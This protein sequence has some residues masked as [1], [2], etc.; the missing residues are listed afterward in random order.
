MTD[1]TLPTVDHSHD[2]P[3]HT[4]ILA[5]AVFMVFSIFLLEKQINEMI[6]AA[7]VTESN[8]ARK[9][10][11]LTDE[12]KE[13]REAMESMKARKAMTEPSANQ[14]DSAATD[15]SVGESAVA[16]QAPHQPKNKVHR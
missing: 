2:V 11:S 4:W 9:V 13:L 7:S 8:A 3:A 15:S 5:V 14:S 12:V 16:K 6:V 1:K 10:N